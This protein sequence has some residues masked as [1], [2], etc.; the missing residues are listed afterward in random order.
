MHDREVK[1]TPM[2]A[3][4]YDIQIM[5]NAIYRYFFCFFSKILTFPDEL[6]QQGLPKMSTIF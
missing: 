5:Q 3:V 4:G 1:V 2:L 6:T